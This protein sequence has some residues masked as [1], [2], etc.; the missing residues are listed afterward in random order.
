MWLFGSMARAAGRAGPRVIYPLGTH[1]SSLSRDLLRCARR[2]RTCPAPR[3][4]AA[5]HPHFEKQRACQ[6]V[7]LTRRD[8]AGARERGPSR[9]RSRALAVRIDACAPASAALAPCCLPHPYLI[10]SRGRADA[11][12]G[13]DSL[14]A[15]NLSRP[16]RLSAHADRDVVAQSHALQPGAR[17]G[18]AAS[19]APAWRP[20]P[21]GA[22]AICLL[23]ICDAESLPVRGDVL[24]V[25]LQP[26]QPPDST[27]R[28]A[29]LT[30]LSKA[31]WWRPRCHG[32]SDGA[33]AAH[34]RA[35]RP[36]R[37]RSAPPPPPVST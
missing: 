9:A 27:S 15:V 6:R 36:S 16:M 33:S 5:R 29:A 35:M 37:R 2:C 25:P 13:S 30:T 11:S 3:A 1:Q 17:C 22:A 4:D 21:P 26:L 10:L 24:R 7:R 28:P 18:R 23:E 34:A 31:C 20:M 32:T 14:V 19:V 8:R 12:D